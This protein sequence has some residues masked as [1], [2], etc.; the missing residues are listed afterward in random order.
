MKKDRLY[1]TEQFGSLDTYI[2]LED[3]IRELRHIGTK[4]EANGWMGLHLQINDNYGTPEIWVVGQRPET[5]EEYKE[6][7]ELKSIIND[8]ELA[9]LARLK[10]KYEDK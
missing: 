10:A 8:R 1:I 7:T 3:I 2:H 5:D 4:A 6:R 9:E